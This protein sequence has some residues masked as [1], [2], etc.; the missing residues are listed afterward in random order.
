M[1]EAGYCEQ[2]GW[3]VSLSNSPT[4]L[5]DVRDNLYSRRWWSI[6]IPDGYNWGWM[7]STGWKERYCETFYS[8]WMDTACFT[9]SHRISCQTMN[10]DLFKQC[11]ERG[12]ILPNSAKTT[13]NRT[14]SEQI[15]PELA[16]VI[17]DS[18][19]GKSYSKGKL[20]GK[21]LPLF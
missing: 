21:V 17:T 1:S 8:K 6:S 13:N 18:K 11:P 12:Q 10:P 7:N 15:K 3:L 14:K 4:L 20:L 5:H 9:A 2:W 16:Q 19:T